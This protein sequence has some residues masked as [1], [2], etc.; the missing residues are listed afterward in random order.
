MTRTMEINPLSTHQNQATNGLIIL[1]TEVYKRAF[2][3]GTLQAHDSRSQAN[4]LLSALT[5]SIGFFYINANLDRRPRRNATFP[6]CYSI[7]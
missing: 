7:R 3:Q 5:R 6:N 4:A 1:V 2:E